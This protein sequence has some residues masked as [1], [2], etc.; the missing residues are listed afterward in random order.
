[1]VE[2]TILSRVGLLKGYNVLGRGGGRVVEPL[3]EGSDFH[4]TEDLKIPTS[5]TA[6][7]A[8][9]RSSLNFVDLK[10][11]EKSSFRI[12]RP[13]LTDYKVCLSRWRRL[14]H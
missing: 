14:F 8:I 7:D 13:P 10:S 5:P 4:I 3:S 9:P 12:T 6:G 11:G 2:W 1:M